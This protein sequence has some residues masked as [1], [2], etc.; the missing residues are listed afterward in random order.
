MAV[1]LLRSKLEATLNRLNLKRKTYPEMLGDIQLVALNLFPG[2]SG[3]NVDN[4]I[5]DNA[6]A[7]TPEEALQRLEQIRSLQEI[8]DLL[9]RKYGNA[10]DTLGKRE[11]LAQIIDGL[12]RLHNSKR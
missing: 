2:G 9:N 3:Q 6:S 11:D 4:I 5:P 12:K 7:G 8:A 10:E 1:E